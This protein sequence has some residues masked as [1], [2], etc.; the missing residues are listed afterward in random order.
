P[1][2]GARGPETKD[3]TV[4]RPPAN[5]WAS[6]GHGHRDTAGLPEATGAHLED[7]PPHPDDHDHDPSL[8]DDVLAPAPEDGPQFRPRR[9]KRRNPVVRWVAIL[10]AV[11]V[12]A[13]GGYV[14]VQGLNG[15]IPEF[16]FGGD[17]EPEDF[18]G[19]GTGEV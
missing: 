9:R 7:H 12:V 2:P 1:G 4:S 8:A 15:L 18:A 14:A 17:S 10:A 19:P 5:D 11:A 6:H 3:A 13:V 16:S